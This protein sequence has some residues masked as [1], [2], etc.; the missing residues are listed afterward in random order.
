MGQF[1]LAFSNLVS[2]L[3]FTKL[4]LSFKIIHQYNWS[5]NS[6][7]LWLFIS[8]SFSSPYFPRRVATVEI[9][10]LNYRSLSPPS[11]LSFPTVPH[12]PLLSP[13]TPGRPSSSSAFHRHPLSYLSQAA[14]CPQESSPSVFCLGR[15]GRPVIARPNL[16]PGGT[17]G[18]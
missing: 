18:P 14:H 8:F 11:C 3:L 1:S 4:S 5:L 17:V 15:D 2:R 9:V 10:Y 7:L 13:T 6:F 12:R 16:C